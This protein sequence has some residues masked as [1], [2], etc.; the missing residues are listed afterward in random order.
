MIK[1]LL[2]LFHRLRIYSFTSC[3]TII[4]FPRCYSSKEP[5]YQCKRCERCGFDPWFRKI[6]WRMKWQPTPVFLPGKSFGQKSLAGYSPW[7]LK[8]VGHDR[9]TKQQQQQKEAHIYTWRTPPSQ[10]NLVNSNTTYV[11]LPLGD[12]GHEGCTEQ[13][14]YRSW[15]AARNRIYTYLVLTNPHGLSKWTDYSRIQSVAGGVIRIL[16]CPLEFPD[17]CIH[18][19]DL[20][21][22]EGPRSL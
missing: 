22:H 2:F 1:K 7:G 3:Y 14:P 6:P 11:A 16:S 12:W 5:A 18:I 9:A 10:T 15:V 8:R 20:C 17:M 19:Y 4:G 13:P 21:I